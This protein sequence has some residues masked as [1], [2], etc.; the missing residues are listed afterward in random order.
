[1]MDGDADSDDLHSP[2]ILHREVSKPPLFWTPQY[3]LR[4]NEL[5]LGSPQKVSH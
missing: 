4:T 2:K 3:T 5:P 1:M